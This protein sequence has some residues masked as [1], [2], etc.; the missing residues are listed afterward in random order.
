MSQKYNLPGLWYLDLWPIGPKQ[1]IITDPDLALHYTVIKN[2]P[3]HPVVGDFVDPIIGKNN[4][5]SVDG[6]RWKRLH[7]MLAPA[8]AI[9]HVRGLAGL[10]AEEVMIFRQILHKRAESREAFSMEEASNNLT[11]DVICKSTFG[12]S[13]N[14]QAKGNPALT[15]FSDI[16]HAFVIERDSWNP[17]KRF[18]ASRKRKAAAKKLD[19]QL[20]KMVRKRYEVVQRDNLDVSK[21]RGLSIMDLVLRERIKES[22]SSAMGSSDALDPEFMEMAITQ[23]KTLLLAGTGT[24][25]DTLCFTYMLLST[26]P[27]V[28]EKLRDEHDRVFTPGIDATYAMLQE[29]PQKMSELEYTNNVIKE[30]LRFF[31]VGNTARAGDSNGIIT[32]NG[33][34][35]PCNDQMICPVQHAMQ[36]DPKIFPNPKA[37]DPDRYTRD[38]S[39]RHAWRPFER[40]PRACLGQTLATDELKLILLLTVRDFDF[41]CADLKPNEKPSVPWTD[42]DL[43]FGDR[44]FQEFIFEAKPRDGMKM[45][46]KKSNRT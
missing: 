45:T 22:R 32:Y 26:H 12:Y 19:S 33:R 29:S 16:C 36:Q 42:L 38:E 7:N 10:I 21:K 8:F 1:L 34:A 44:A 4:I 23:I 25:T 14:A 6:P 31:P 41:K 9:S 30:T 37:F 40:G 24:T 35:Y 27:E 11:F 28:V 46:V 39:P 20:D 18:F 15:H 2:L 17:I 43:A 13:L 3:K 5:V